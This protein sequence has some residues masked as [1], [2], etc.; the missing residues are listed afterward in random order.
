MGEARKDEGGLVD[1]LSAFERFR[2]KAGKLPD[3]LSDMAPEYVRA[4][5]ADP[6]PGWF[7]CLP[8]ASTICR[9]RPYPPPW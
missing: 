5:A 3:K 1:F 6:L 8:P 9:L 2:L 7:I 4:V